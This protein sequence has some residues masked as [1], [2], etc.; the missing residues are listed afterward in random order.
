MVEIEKIVLSS[1]SSPFPTHSKENFKYFPPPHTHVK[2]M[3]FHQSTSQQLVQKQRPQRDVAG[4]TGPQTFAPSLSQQMSPLSL[5]LFHFS[6]QD[7]TMALNE[8][9]IVSRQLPFV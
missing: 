9:I 7:I 4:K 1:W 3:Q 8:A 2:K 6:L 5:I